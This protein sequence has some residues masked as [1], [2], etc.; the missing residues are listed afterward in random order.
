MG[1]SEREKE[2]ER[3]V[4][5][6]E[7]TK[8]QKRF[9]AEDESRVGNSTGMLEK[10]K[11]L[12]VFATKLGYQT[13][14][15]DEAARKLGVDVVFITDRCHQLDDP[16]GD[17]AIAV[18]FESPDAAAYAVLEAVRGGDQ[19]DG[20]L[21]FGDR[22]AVAAAY[23][24]RGL[25]VVYNHPAAVE[26]C[27]SKL[28]MREVFRDAGLRGPWFRTV[29][30]QPAPEPALL[31]ISYPCVLKPMS[32][33]ASQGVIRAN[34]RNEFLAAADRIRKLL[35]SP[36]ILATREPSLDHLLVEGYIPGRELAL[37]GLLTDGQLRVLAIFDKPD[38]LE[39]PF[40]EETIYVTPSRLTELELRD[41][42]RCA[43]DAVRALGLTQGPVH[44]EFRINEQ[45]VWPLEVA[46]R[47]IG[48]LCSRALRF[49]GVED[50]EPVGLEELLLRHAVDL[51]DGLW[52]RESL[53]SGVMMIS[54]P[55]SGVLEKVA[56][57]DQVRS[58]SGVTELQI[59]AR[60]HDY[61]A[62]WPEGSTYLGFLFARA[63]RPAEVE[64][65]L[66]DAHAK[67]RFTIAP[68]L[69]VEHPATR[70]MVS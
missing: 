30:S 65:I 69:P 46:P 50:R 6:H 2:T 4:A 61:I 25:G 55:R 67:L 51:P 33:S 58:V 10:S 68:R 66:R 11:R 21:T 36:E 22:P 43:V 53:A 42:E 20:I 18:H 40:F 39:G 13:R 15:L 32:L 37:E 31:G 63:E 19:I 54:V 64:Q 14:S 60:L 24:A 59:T 41:V 49:Q 29:A 34:S 9:G 70:G 35:T 62:A 45:G 23:V 44:A 7:D 5:D 12:L 1:L 26:A 3:F 52:P 17:R 38:P 16:W 48:G 56:G 47:P 57:E 28:R 27:R 8:V